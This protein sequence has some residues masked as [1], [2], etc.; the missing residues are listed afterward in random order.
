M[1][2]KNNPLNVRFNSLNRW[3]G[4]T[5]QTRGFCDF[6]SEYY[7]VR[8]AMYLLIRSYK[9][10]NIVTYSEMIKRYAPPTENNTGA[11]VRFICESM[12][13][14]PFDVPLYLSNWIDLFYYMSKY[15]GNSLSKDTIE[16]YLYKFLG[17]SK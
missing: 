13:V 4:L 7:G 5:G 9:A 2:G 16:K 12:N 10:R 14:F 3:R 8:A 1:I 17:E 6:E 11:Y 15:E